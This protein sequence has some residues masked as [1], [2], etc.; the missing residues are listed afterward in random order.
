MRKSIDTGL[1]TY[2]WEELCTKVYT[3]LDDVMNDAER[4]EA[5]KGCKFDL[6]PTSKGILRGADS[7][8]D[9]PMELGA[10]HIKNL[11]PDERDKRMRQGLCLRCRQPGHMDKD[12]RQYDNSGNA[13]LDSDGTNNGNLE[14]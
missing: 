2:I 14:N 10:V 11:T 7:T 3:S 12:Y 13:A 6:A 1:K 9:A 4:V 5:A 8:N